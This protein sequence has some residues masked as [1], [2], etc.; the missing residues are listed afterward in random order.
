LGFGNLP[1]KIIISTVREAFWRVEK[2]PSPTLEMRLFQGAKQLR[3]FYPQGFKVRVIQ[4]LWMQRF[5][6][7]AP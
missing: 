6:H 2:H 3:L 4:G 7:L 5:D 1:L